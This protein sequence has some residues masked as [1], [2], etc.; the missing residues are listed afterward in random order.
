M[1][2]LVFVRSLRG[3]G[4]LLETSSVAIVFPAV[5]RAANAFLIDASKS[6]RGA[7]MRTMLADKTVPTL[8]IPVDNQFFAEKLDRLDRFLIG[9]LSGRRDRV[10]VA[11]QQFSARRAAPDSS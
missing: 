3:L 2:D 4:R 8:F 6:E 10:P 1:F 9:Q 7:S 5:I 11:A